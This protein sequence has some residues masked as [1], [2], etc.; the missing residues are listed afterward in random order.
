MEKQ[1]LVEGLRKFETEEV[2]SKVVKHANWG[3]KLSI[4]SQFK[5]LM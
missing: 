3:S 2:L 5:Q 1:N 4:H